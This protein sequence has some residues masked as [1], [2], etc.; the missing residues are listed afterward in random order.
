MSCKRLSPPPK[1]LRRREASTI[2]NTSLNGMPRRRAACRSWRS[3]IRLRSVRCSMRC[4]EFCCSNTTIA[5]MSYS[6]R[7]YREG[8]RSCLGSRA[9]LAY[10]LIRFHCGSRAMNIPLSVSCC[11][12]CMIRFWRPTGTTMFRLPIFSQ[13]RC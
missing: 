13:E 3:T 11:T 9:W 5:R 2:A 4:G 8:L 6:V 10:S 12:M 7:S 1:G